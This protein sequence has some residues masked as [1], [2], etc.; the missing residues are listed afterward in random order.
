MILPDDFPLYKDL[1]ISKYN[2][3]NG[4]YTLGIIE[5]HRP[6]LE[7]IHSGMWQSYRDYEWLDNKIA[8]ALEDNKTVGLF[9]W[10]ENISFNS[11]FIKCLLKY[12]SNPVY[13]ISQLDDFSIFCCYKNQGIQNIIE[14]PW[15]L[16]NDCLCYYR[17][18]NSNL[19]TNKSESDYNFLCMVNRYEKHKLN[20]I[21]ELGNAGLYQF[22]YITVSDHSTVDAD[23]QNFCQQSPYLPYSNLSQ[24]WAARCQVADAVV[25]IDF[26]NT[27]VNGIHISA[28]VENFLQIEKQYPTIPLIINPE[29]S[30]GCFFTT[31]KSLWPL[32]LGRLCL[33][34]GRRGVMRDIQRFYDVDFSSYINLEFDEI[35]GWTEQDQ[36]NRVSTMISHNKD[37]IKDSKD[38]YQSLQ[39]KLE[40]ARWTIGKNMYD[41][42]VRQIAQ[43][44]KIN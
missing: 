11:L 20:L 10:D 15:W 37:L 19:L 41:F 22:G 13:I 2:L 8:A 23:I 35:Q 31:E 14:V 32:L 29:T 5:K 27:E 26:G 42:F 7:I 30:Y 18:Y 43:I 17:V 3:V 6:D 1:D 25:N 21:R 12:Q 28:N 9:I 4:V 44:P 33:I 39:S 34:S 24:T 40:Q 38:I 36:Q 16:L